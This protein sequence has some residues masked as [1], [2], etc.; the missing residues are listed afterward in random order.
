MEAIIVQQIKQFEKNKGTRL[1][2]CQRMITG[3]ILILIV[4]CVSLKVIKSVKSMA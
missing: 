4:N 2:S 3:E 1:V